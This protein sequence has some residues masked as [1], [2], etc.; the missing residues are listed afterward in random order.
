MPTVGLPGRRSIS[1]DSACNPRHRSSVSVVI[2]LYFTPASGL[3]SNVVTTG[4]GFICTTEPRTLNSSSFDLIRAAMSFNSWLSYPFPGGTSFSSSVPGS[5][6]TR[7]RL[8]R[9]GSGVNGSRNGGSGSWR[10]GSR[11]PNGLIFQRPDRNLVVL[12]WLFL[13]RLRLHIERRSVVGG[14][15][16]NRS[17]HR[18]CFL[19]AFG[20]CGRLRFPAR[21]SFG[22]LGLRT[23]NRLLA[24]HLPSRLPSRPNGLPLRDGA[25]QPALECRNFKAGC[26]IQRDNPGRDRDN[27]R[28]GHIEPREQKIRHHHADNSAGPDRSS[29]QPGAGN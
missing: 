25:A 14:L 26:E 3:Y 23:L 20:S 17:R 9:V 13:R 7:F 24:P 29:N 19:G 1:T 16:C 27:G 18:S 28:T 4:P 6:Y 15:F 21:C 2:R 12:H 10:F 8:L 11:C 5:L 22:S